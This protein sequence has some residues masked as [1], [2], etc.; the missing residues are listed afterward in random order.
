[1]TAL[2]ILIAISKLGTIWATKR[3]YKKLFQSATSIIIMLIVIKASESRKPKYED[4][5]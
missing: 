1:M 5:N 2:T 3:L 4:K